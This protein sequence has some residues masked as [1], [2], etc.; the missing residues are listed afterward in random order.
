M[1]ATVDAP[2][3]PQ[4]E[5]ASFFED[6]IDIITSPAKVFARRADS[7]FFLP[8]LVITVLVGVLFLANRGT[9]DGIMDGE[10]NRQMRAAMEKN[11]SVTAEQMQGMRGIGESIAPIAAFVVMPVLMLLLGLGVMFAGRIVGAPL[12]Y[13]ASAM[14]A[15]WSYVPRVVES[16]LVAI[17][18]LVLDTG[19]LTGRFQLSLG[20]GRFLDPDATAPGLLAILGRVDLITLWITVLVGIGISVV[21][22]VPRGKAI[23]AATALWCVG[24]LPGIIQLLMA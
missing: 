2:I 7:G 22:K 12:T 17:Q 23:A 15:T 18:G 24:A 13:G 16:I 6:L 3:S 8:L 11:P 1:N 4:P 19:T 10:F 9:M 21:G 14:I 20:V 5:Q